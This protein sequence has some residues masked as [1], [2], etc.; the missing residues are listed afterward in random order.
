L[1]YSVEHHDD[2]F[3]IT[4]NEEAKNFKIVQAP[5]SAPGKENWKEF[6]P[7]DPEIKIDEVNAF[8]DY[9]VVSER[10]NGL[11]AIQIFKFD[12]GQTQNI[13]FD[14]PAYDVSLGSNHEFN[15]TLVRLSYSSF[16]T[17]DSVIDYDMSTGTRSVLKEMPV[18]G[19]YSKTDYVAE[20]VFAKSNDGVKVP[21]SIFYRK[22]TKR[23]GTAPLWLTG[24][25]AYGVPTDAD[26]DPDRISLVNR[27]FVFA[28]AHIR[29]G[30]ELGRAWYEDGKLLK[31]KN[32]FYD[33][34]R[35]TE[36]L[37][38]EKYCSPKQIVI[39]GASAG[40]LLMG[41]VMNM[42]PE[43]YTTVIADV[44]FV[45]LLN[46]MSDPTLPLTITEYD[47]WG[48]P[49]RPDYYEYMASYSPYDQVHDVHYPNLF[50]TAGLND[51]RVSYWEPA[52]WVAKQRTL[53]HQNRILLLK[54]EMGAGH[55]GLSGRYEQLRDAATEYAFAI[56]TLGNKEAVGK[57]GHNTKSSQSQ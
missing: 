15:T 27:G 34:I 4:T 32:S 39:A 54:T 44:P 18:L 26:F 8:K 22:G 20:R 47:E 48:N 38:D 11:P 17:P 10:K 37:V 29:G 24:Y 35:C 7:Y 57:T 30:G 36:Y 14:E 1:L 9:L 16:I 6:L 43:L 45:D 5:V 55:G 40:G 2:R 31:K 50:V 49:E 12:T 46:T 56:S 21:I 51:T 3:L 33:F 41:A 28:I 53:K 23:D 13:S 52:K 42:R 25:G 19:G